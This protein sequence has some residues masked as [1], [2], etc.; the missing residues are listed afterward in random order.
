MP[1]LQPEKPR[2][3]ESFIAQL[4]ALEPDISVVVAVR[5][6]P[7]RRDHRSP[8]AS[9]RSTCTRRC[10]PRCAAPRRSRLPIRDGTRGDGRHDHA[11]GAGARRRTDHAAGAHAD[12]RDETAG[13]L[14]LRLSELG[15][16]ALIEALALIALGKL[17]GDAAG[18]CARHVR[19]QDRARDGAH[20]LDARRGHHRPARA[21]VRPQARRVHIAPRRRSQ[22]LRPRGVR[23]RAGAQRRAR[24][25]ARRSTPAA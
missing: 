18:R 1:V 25:G 3:D 6:H 8:D 20:R 14:E 5:P 10:S 9:A 17:H 12:P 11:D 24:R 15:A 4:R 23:G 16:L 13:E 22:A 21:R 2:G 19:A 7:R